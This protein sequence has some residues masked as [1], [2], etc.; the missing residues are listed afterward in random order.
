V[1]AFE[2]LGRAV[3]AAWG[4]RDF[5]ERA[6]P[7]VAA[8]ALRERQ[9]HRAIGAADVLHWLLAA[10][11]LLS[12]H[13][14]GATFGDPPITVYRG[15]RF[16]IET[17][18]WLEGSTVIHRHAFSGAFQ[19]LDG[20][21]LHTRYAFDVRRRVSAR[22]LVGDLRLREA[23]VLERG[24]VTE[25]DADLIHGLF[26][27]DTPSASVVVRTGRE[28]DIGPAFAYFPPSVAEDPLAARDEVTVRRRQGLR[29]ARRAFPSEYPALAASAIATSDLHTAYVVLRD[30]FHGRGDPAA[31]GPLVEATKRRHGAVASD[32]LAS[33]Q[34]QLR[35]HKL[36]RL[37]AGERDADRRLFLTLLRNLPDRDAIYATL[38]QLRPGSDPRER[39]VAWALALS[40][41]GA[42]GVNLADPLN[43]QIFEALL[44][45]SE[46]DALL[47]RLGEA[48]TPDEVSAAA[49]RLL[50]HA[51][52]IRETALA[53]L[54]CSRSA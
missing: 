11:E 44:D 52:R 21:S 5:D 53:P 18:L 1:R 51:A 16:F 36:G 19:V 47:A 27:L 4:A 33:I 41:V 13:D 24:A 26:H 38:R 35:D 29:F 3:E 48:F 10:P 15:R 32:L 40:G 23:E 39:V 25:I 30:A 6:F 37:Q 49:P 9:I 42:I 43:R 54:F 34:Q 50:R 2:E 20:S 8:A 22:L 14:L 45:G 7:G 28:S 31:L 46:G 12:Q 17:I